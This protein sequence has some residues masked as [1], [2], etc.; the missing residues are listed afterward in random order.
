MG[1]VTGPMAK[2]VIPKPAVPFLVALGGA[3]GPMLA[4][5]LGQVHVA[6]MG[7]GGWAALVAT[8]LALVV[9]LGAVL[10]SAELVSAYPS[11]QGSLAALQRAFSPRV[12]VFALAAAVVALLATAAG[13]LLAA[14]ELVAPR[15]HLPSS[16]AL[17]VLLALGVSIGL[18]GIGEVRRE[19]LSGLLA[20]VLL[21]LGFLVVAGL[22]VTVWESSRFVASF[23]PLP[24]VSPLRLA[25]V[26]A[27]ALLGPLVFQ[28]GAS[29]L[30]PRTGRPAFVASRAAAAGGFLTLLFGTAASVI[31]SGLPTALSPGSHAALG[32]LLAITF[33][34]IAVHALRIARLLLGRLVDKRWLGDRTARTLPLVVLPLPILLAHLDAGAAARLGFA[35]SGLA[36]LGFVSF[37]FGA[38]YRLR[39]LDDSVPRQFRLGP[40]IAGRPAFVPLA[41]VLA[42]LLAVLIVV[43]LPLGAAIAFGTLTIVF[44]ACLSSTP[45][46]REAGDRAAEHYEM[47]KRAGEP[48]LAQ[49]YRAALERGEQA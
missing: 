23:D 10:A 26:A 11:G 48:E 4:L 21:V 39:R 1:S 22:L 5:C 45:S 6:G 3:G 36:Y 13:A 44:A 33:G 43:A 12:A 27:V 49:Q 14:T 30:A 35:A 15:A 17:A 32:L 37:V 16:V 19:K 29:L 18:E 41:L 34:F 38:L 20:A 24:G 42:L 25:A 2:L 46:K 40:T 28:E 47:L 31:R 7:W 8:L 9:G